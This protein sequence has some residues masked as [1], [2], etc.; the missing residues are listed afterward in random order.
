MHHSGVSPSG[1][2]GDSESPIRRFESYHSN[3][4][5]LRLI[6]SLQLTAVSSLTFWVCLLMEIWK[7]YTRRIYAAKPPSK[8]TQ[9]KMLTRHIH[10]WWKMVLVLWTYP[11]I[12]N[13]KIQRPEENSKSENTN[14]N[15]LISEEIIDDKIITEIIISKTIHWARKSNWQSC[16][17]ILYTHTN[18]IATL[19]IIT[20]SFLFIALTSNSL[21]WINTCE[22]YYAPGKPHPVGIERQCRM[23]WDHLSYQAMQS[24][25]NLH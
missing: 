25:P 3:H 14:K 10:C 8:S 7:R 15:P 16:S 19:K 9:C 2:A 1:K 23:I 17:F 11:N 12:E 24:I 18:M 20:F 22:S 21:Y 6:K 4:L 5:Y 13:K